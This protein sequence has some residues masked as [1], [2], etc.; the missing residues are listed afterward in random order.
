[1]QSTDL[2]SLFQKGSRR[3]LLADVVL[4]ALVAGPLAA[5][6]LAASGFFPFSLIAQIIYW[7]GGHVCPQP[8]TGLALMPPHLMAVCMRCY[9]TLTGVVIM[10]WLYQQN[11]GQAAYWLSRYG[12]IGF[13]ATIGFCL[14]YPAELWA[15]YWGWWG[16][17]NWVVFPFGLVSGLGLGAYIMPWLH[18]NSTARENKAG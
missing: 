14:V 6:F 1:M 8:E 16:Y 13:I 4:V 11:S 12:L 10:R 18:G 3:S 9:G 15:E 7:M 17:N 5:P 2:S